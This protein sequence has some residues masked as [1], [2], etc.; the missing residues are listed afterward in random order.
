MWGSSS[1]CAICA[2]GD[3]ITEENVMKLKVTYSFYLLSLSLIMMVSIIALRHHALNNYVYADNRIKKH[4]AQIYNGA[5]HDN[6]AH[7]NVAHCDVTYDNTA[8]DYTSMSQEFVFFNAVNLANFE[9]KKKERARHLLEQLCNV[10]RIDAQCNLSFAR[11]ALCTMHNHLYADNNRQQF[12]IP[13]VVRTGAHASYTH[14]LVKKIA[15]KQLSEKK[16]SP[17]KRRMVSALEKLLE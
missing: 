17:H 13:Q 15:T 4:V 11:I 10:K 5:A 14:A 3:L 8:Y 16:M 7:D 6:A 9:H 2:I 12:A 1:F